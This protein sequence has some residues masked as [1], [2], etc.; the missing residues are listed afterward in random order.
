MPDIDDEKVADAAAELDEKD[1]EEVGGGKWADFYSYAYLTALAAAVIGGV[2]AVYR[3]V[4][5]GVIETDVSLS[6][7]ADIGWVVEWFL[8]GI[9]LVV[10]FWTVLQV[11]NAA[12]IGFINSL[13]NVIAEAADGYEK[14]R[15][16]DNE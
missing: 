1:L 4:R 9:L 8:A 15:G 16:G 14:D 6:V 5:A 13:K 7:N 12:G 11:I 2:Y 10:M 3:L